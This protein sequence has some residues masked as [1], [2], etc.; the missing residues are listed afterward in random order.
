[1]GGKRS[2]PYNRVFCWEGI[3]RPMDASK[4]YY[5]KS[6]QNKSLRLKF[7]LNYVRCNPTIGTEGNLDVLGSGWWGWSAMV[8]QVMVRTRLVGWSLTPQPREP[9]RWTN[10]ELSQGRTL[11]K[12]IASLGWSCSL[13]EGLGPRSLNLKKNRHVNRI[14]CLQ[15]QATAKHKSS[16]NSHGLRTMGYRDEKHGR[17]SYWG[18]VC[19][20]G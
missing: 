17:L 4:H 6:S 13:A 3:E 5:W 9:A 19:P 12:E 20:P 7:F 15:L 16:G 14:A 2:L 10:A 11:Y 18:Y 1:M 8:Q